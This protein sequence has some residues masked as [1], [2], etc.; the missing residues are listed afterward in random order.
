MQA[1]TRIREYPQ[2]IFIQAAGSHSPDLASTSCE[3]HL[4]MILQKKR[5][6]RP[7]LKIKNPKFGERLNRKVLVISGFKR[8]N[9]ESCIAP[10]LGA[11]APLE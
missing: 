11:E 4:P 2:R 6:S 9:T 10:Y 8:F 1:S 3:V 7:F 5:Y